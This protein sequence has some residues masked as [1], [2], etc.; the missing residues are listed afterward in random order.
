MAVGLAGNSSELILMKLTDY[1][2]LGKYSKIEWVSKGLILKQFVIWDELVKIS[3]IC[4]F[5]YLNGK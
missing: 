5:L 2:F 4:P 3:R 1:H